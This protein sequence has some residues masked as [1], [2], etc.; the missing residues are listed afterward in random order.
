MVC[1]KELTDENTWPVPIHDKAT[2]NFGYWCR[3]CYTIFI[4]NGKT[5]AGQ[6]QTIRWLH[7]EI[8]RLEEIIK[9]KDEE[10]K[11][12]KQLLS[13]KVQID[14]NLKYKGSREI[15]YGRRKEDN[16]NRA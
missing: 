16:G 8:D 9:K 7:R 11:T 6:L 4:G 13:M 1:G 3:D 14:K 5:I 10:I 12:F 15:Y 2:G